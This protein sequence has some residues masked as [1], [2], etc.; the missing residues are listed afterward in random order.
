MDMPK[1]PCY[2]CI[3]CDFETAFRD[4][5]AGI[6]TKKEWPRWMPC[7]VHSA[8]CDGSGY[9]KVTEMYSCV[10]YQEMNPIDH[11]QQIL[12]F[13]KR[14]EALLAWRRSTRNV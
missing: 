5:S 9:V 1:E 12:S 11:W 4:G 10:S 6:A 2:S 3:H 8:E 14:I 7:D 13:D